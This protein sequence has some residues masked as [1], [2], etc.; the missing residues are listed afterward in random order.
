MANIFDSPQNI[1][2]FIINL[3]TTILTLFAT[4]LKIGVD[5]LMD[6]L[7]SASQSASY[8]SYIKTVVTTV[9]NFMA[10]FVILI[11]SIMT[12]I[13]NLFGQINDTDS[14]TK[15]VSLTSDSGN[16]TRNDEDV[17]PFSLELEKKGLGGKDITLEPDYSVDGT[18]NFAIGYYLWSGLTDKKL[19]KQSI[20]YLK[21]KFF[22]NAPKLL[23]EVPSIVP[24]LIDFDDYTQNDVNG[25]KIPSPLQ[26]VTLKVKYVYTITSSSNVTSTTVVD[27]NES[28]PTNGKLTALR[29]IVTGNLTT[30][31]VSSEDLTE[32]IRINGR[33][34]LANSLVPSV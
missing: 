9:K 7:D 21:Y 19:E 2:E 5:Y 32:K 30:I 15:I 10:N 8:Y 6:L 4:Y 34:E 18:L 24:E 16:L 13:L 29:F 1:I 20:Q 12:Y 31:N 33:T 17:R 3:L 27:S 23:T 22:L 28:V 14:Y 11:R 25:T 26:D